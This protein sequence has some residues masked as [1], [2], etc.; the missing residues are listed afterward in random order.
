[1]LSTAV[2][3]SPVFEAGRDVTAK[4]GFVY[5]PLVQAAGAKCHQLQKFIAP[6]LGV[7]VRARADGSPEAEALERAS[8]STGLLDLVVGLQAVLG[9]LRRDHGSYH[10]VSPSRCS[11]KGP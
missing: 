8:E 9:H 5:P 3:F 6:L 7:S 4:R 10:R 2:G 1:M 11:N